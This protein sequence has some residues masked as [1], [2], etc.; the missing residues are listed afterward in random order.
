MPQD[1]DDASRHKRN[2]N[3][4]GEQ[5]GSLDDALSNEPRGTR[6]EGSTR[7]RTFGPLCGHTRR[8]TES[9]VPRRRPSSFAVGHEAGGGC[10]TPGFGGVGIGGEIDTGK[11]VDADENVNKYNEPVGTSEG[12]GFFRI[13]WGLPRGRPMPVDL[14]RRSSGY[15]FDSSHALDTAADA[16]SPQD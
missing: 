15:S 4:N 13:A 10:E 7:R 8:L 6:K 12:E 14:P 1:G 3:L 5:D 9:T 2:D 11:V 16:P